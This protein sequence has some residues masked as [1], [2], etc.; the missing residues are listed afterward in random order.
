ME[1][2]GRFVFFFFTLSELE[3]GVPLQCV[4]IQPFRRIVTVQPIRQSK[5]VD[6]RFPK[7][8]NDNMLIRT[9]M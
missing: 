9:K 5:D 6:R 8:K 2:C 4:T 7:W 3:H 1:S